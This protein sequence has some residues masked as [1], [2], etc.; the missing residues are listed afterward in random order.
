M[1]LEELRSQ[2]KVGAADKSEQAKLIGEEGNDAK[3]KGNAQTIEEPQLELSEEGAAEEAAEEAAV[4]QKALIKA[5]EEAAALKKE[6]DAV[7][8]VEILR[9]RIALAEF[10]STR[11]TLV[12]S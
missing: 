10:S 7:Q 2:N 12:Q 8:K 3:L 4:A 6:D 5:A 1:A 11:P 9:R